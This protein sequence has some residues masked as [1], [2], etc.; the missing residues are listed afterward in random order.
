MGIDLGHTPHE[1]LVPEWP[2]ILAQSGGGEHA[3]AGAP[4]SGW[5]QEH[6]RQPYRGI[7]GYTRDA[8]RSGV[9]RS[10]KAHIH[11][12]VGSTDLSAVSDTVTNRPTTR[13]LTNIASAP[14]QPMWQRG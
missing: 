1:G 5:S 7:R 10:A 14:E 13:S 8:R 4:V 2:G 3:P 12:A 9:R 6:L 11:G